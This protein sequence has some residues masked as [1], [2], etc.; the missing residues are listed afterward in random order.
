MDATDRKLL[1]LIQRDVPVVP[2]P[3]DAL[4]EPLGLS[5]EEVLRRVQTLKAA[6]I[7]RQISAIFDTR[8]LGYTSTLVA[9]RCLPQREAEVAAVI[10]Q[11]PGVSH[12]YARNHPFNLWFTIAVSPQSRFGLE[13]TVEILRQETNAEALRLLPALRV[14]KI[15][16]QLDVEADDTQENDVACEGVRHVTPLPLM[17]REMEFVRAMQRDLPLVPEPFAETGFT[18]QELRQLAAAMRAS[19]RLRRFGAV[20]QHRRAGFHA[21]A[22]GVWIVRGPETEVE[23]AGKTMARFRAVSHCYQRPTYPDWPYNLFTMVHGHTEAECEAVLAGISRATGLTEYAALY[24][25]CEY[26]KTR[27]QYFT[28]AESAWEQQ[29]ATA[30][31]VAPS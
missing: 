7:I 9:V 3:W 17:P 30:A 22:M 13:R 25:T 20:L 18:I 24:S 31:V 5:G 2:R 28:E 21:N 26:K 15:G 8:S 11:H 10:N 4:G 27:V 19:G 29:H 1:S 12:N 14:F 16:V 6:G 23:T